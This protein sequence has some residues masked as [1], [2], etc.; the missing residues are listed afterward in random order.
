MKSR[1]YAQRAQRGKPVHECN[2][3]SAVVKI[4]IKWMRHRCRKESGVE[5]G[6]RKL[7]RSWFSCEYLIIIPPSYES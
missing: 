4:F 5:S 7:K 1:S 2:M 3:V 6:D